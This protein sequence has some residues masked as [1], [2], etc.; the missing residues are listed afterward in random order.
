MQNKTI[1]AAPTVK[2]KGARKN[3]TKWKSTF[4]VVVGIACLLFLLELQIRPIL[5]AVIDYETREYVMLSFQQAVQMHLEE[6]PE[7]YENL[8]ELTYDAD[9]VPTS[10]VANS[11]QMN[12]IRSQLAQQVLDTLWANSENIYEFHLGRLSGIQ[13]LASRGPMIT[14]NM[15]PQSYV[16]T[17]LYN[18]IETVGENQSLLSIYVEI[19]VQVNV[20]MAGYMQSVSVQNDILLWQN[21]LLGRV[22]DVNV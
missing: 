11:Y 15:Q 19:T 22:P 17:N 10:V 7:S 2:I 9:E 16:I 8:Y 13:M 1:T 3:R 20:K 6:H 18:T 5:R 4:L 14:L 12:V 21:L